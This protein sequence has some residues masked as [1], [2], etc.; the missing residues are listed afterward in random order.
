M[1]PNLHSIERYFSELQATIAE[2]S[3]SQVAQIIEILLEANRTGRKIFIFGN[4][5]SAS[6]ASHFACDLAK[7]TIVPGV[8][9]FKVITLNDNIP[10]MTAW[11]NDTAF[12]NIYAEQL[13]SLIEPYD[14]VIG[15]SCSG[16]SGNVLKAVKAARDCGSITIALT[17]DQGGQL[18]DMVDLCVTVPSPRIEQQEDV[19]LILE[20]CI[21]AIIK[22]VLAR[23]VNIDLPPRRIAQETV[24]VNGRG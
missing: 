2:L 19:H 3:I 24:F 20:H 14:V 5:G 15:I 21:C 8:P 7:N 11:A 17:G 13:I 18:K 16:N 4:G 23:Q 9:R 22:D 1:N 10:S 6:T 12:D